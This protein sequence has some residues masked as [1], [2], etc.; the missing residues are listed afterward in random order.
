MVALGGFGTIMIATGCGTV[1]TQREVGQLNLTYA[2]PQGG[3]EKT[4]KI[5]GVVSK[6]S[7][8]EIKE[9]AESPSMKL[10]ASFAPRGGSYDNTN[11]TWNARQDFRS[12]YVP[13]L[14]TAISN[15]F[16]EILSKRGFNVKGPYGTFDDMTFG[17]KR[18]IFLVSNSNISIDVDKKS[19]RFGCDKGYCTDEGEFQVTG[20]L[21]LQLIEP[22]TGQTVMTKR[23]NLSDFQISKAYLKQ[24]KAPSEP[25]AMEAILNMTSRPARLVDN[26]DKVLVEAVNEFYTRAMAKIDL[27]LSRDEI[28]SHDKEV[29]EL[30]NLKRF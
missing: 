16:G 23:I 3:A 18:E 7:A 20:E 22:L 29:A 27:F 25:G 14:A 26:T 4:G 19:T 13:R 28:M 8:A 24:V 5:L 30:K 21:T 15:G 12:S 2:A 1:P 9:P 17:E 10:L 11:F 6:T